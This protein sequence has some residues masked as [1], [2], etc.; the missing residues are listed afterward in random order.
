MLS[1]FHI[2]NTVIGSKANSRCMRCGEY[3]VDDRRL[4]IHFEK[5][6]ASP[7][8]IV[9]N[10]LACQE[11][12][13]AFQWARDLERHQRLHGNHADDRLQVNEE[14]R[15]EGEEDEE[16]AMKGAISRKLKQSNSQVSRTTTDFLYR[17]IDMDP[18]GD[19]YAV[20]LALDTDFDLASKRD[21]VEEEE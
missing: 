15:S 8:K 13:R 1:N 17:D 3:F 18:Y 14:L 16:E 12:G 21:M 7:E 2:D 11:C 20:C 6:H 9:N 19:E 5:T 10:N 4:Q